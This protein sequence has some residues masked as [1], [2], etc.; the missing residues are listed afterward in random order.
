MYNFK[1]TFLVFIAFSLLVSSCRKSE[2]VVSTESTSLV[3][4]TN[5]AITPLNESPATPATIPGIPIPEQSSPSSLP[6]VNEP[7]AVVSNT[8]HLVHSTVISSNVTHISALTST[9]TLV[10]VPAQTNTP[11][12][13]VVAP[14]LVGPPVPS[15]SV[16]SGKKSILVLC[17]HRFD[18]PGNMYS[19]S[20]EAFRSQMLALKEKGY[21][22]I[23]MSKAIDFWNKKST[24]L[25][26]KSAVI[27]IDD[28][29][30]HVHKRAYPIL[31][32]LNYPWVFYVYTDFINTGGDS[33]T[34][35]ELKEMQQNGMEIGCHSKSHSLMTQRK[36]KS[37]ENYNAW[38]DQETAV[39]KKLIEDNL[40]VPC[41][42]FAY[43]YGGHNAYVRKMTE[44]AGFEGICTVAGVINTEATDPHNINRYVITRDFSFESALRSATENQSLVLAEHSPTSGTFA[45]SARP[46]LSVRVTNADEFDLNSATMTLD[47]KK[48]LPAKLTQGNLLTTTLEADLTPGVHRIV[49]RA[50][51]RG[52]GRTREAGWFFTIPSVATQNIKL[53]PSP[54][55]T[56]SPSINHSTNAPTSPTKNP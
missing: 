6:V 2:T 29:F 13:V 42:T 45:E 21:T 43:P 28:G 12:P 5:T 20:S 11:P 36:G 31:K 18:Q 24:D 10:S 9:P 35:E 32:E 47:K 1:S 4:V 14:P 54:T 15:P 41:R 48:T 23:P 22:V 33:I 19:I 16:A 50:K 27:T 30:K 17:Y 25:P 53:P 52:T 38:L 51:D 37:E 49:V 46:A 26:A 7:P 3:S 44:A 39:A 40:G 34:W 8:A 55:G 56:N